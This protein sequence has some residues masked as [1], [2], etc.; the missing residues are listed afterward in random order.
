VQEWHDFHS[1]TD[2]ERQRI[3]REIGW[4][5]DAIPTPDKVGGETDS[6]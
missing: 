3:L 1:W 5:V 4:L 6:S 2:E